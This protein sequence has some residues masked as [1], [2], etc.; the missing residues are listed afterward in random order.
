MQ[1]ANYFFASIVSYLG[2]V[3]GIILIKIAPEEQNPLKKSFFIMRGL[4]LLLIFV[5]SIFY[6]FNNSFYFFTL[7]AYFLFL[8]FVEYKTSNLIRK[9]MLSYAVL[10]VVFFL[11]SANANLFAIESS[12]ILLYGMP[13]ASLILDKKGGNEHK[14][15]FYNL[16]F[17]IISN[18]LYFV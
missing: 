6:F 4:L 7:I 9:S 10:G 16:G 12:L 14:I 17:V 2:L 18:I 1:L 5:F 13:M 8:L 3:I 15:I 11:S